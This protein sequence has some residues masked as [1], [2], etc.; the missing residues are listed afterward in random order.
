MRYRGGSSTRS[1][2]LAPPLRP[3]ARSTWAGPLQVGPPGGRRVS[4]DPV[5]LTTVHA[6]VGILRG[7]GSRNIH[8]IF[9]LF[10]HRPGT[11]HPG[12][13]SLLVLNAS[14]GAEQWHPHPHRP[15]A[16]SDWR[17]LRAAG[18]ADRIDLRI[19]P[20]I[21][22]LRSLPPEP[23]IDLAFI[24]ADKTGYMTYYEE[25]LP[26][27]SPRGVILVDNTLWHGMILEDSGAEDPDTAA[28]RTFNDHVAADERVETVLLTIGDGVTLIRHR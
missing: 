26:R 14:S 16:A 19:A 28:L 4:D 7:G 10:L 18:V 3:G 23:K 21:E 27:L 1:G 22:T 8:R 20:A 11:S 15:N 25:I 6:E 2:R 17:F 9:G 12:G 13:R 5:F 24:D